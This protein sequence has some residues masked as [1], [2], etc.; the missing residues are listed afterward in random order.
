[1]LSKKFG[2]SIGALFIFPISFGVNAS[3]VTYANCPTM[4]PLPVVGF[5]PA[6]MEPINTLGTTYDTALQSIAQAVTIATTEQS[7]AIDSAF[8]MIM[9][10]MVETSQ[11]QHMQEIEIDRQ[12][13]EM[14][15]A[16]EAD[17]ADRQEQLESMLF[18]GDPSM[19]QP[20]EGEVRAIDPDS[21]SYKFV[22]QMCTSGKMQQMMTSRSVVNRAVENRNR[23]N[24]KITN[25]IQVVSSID[26]AAKQNIDMHYDI[27]CSPDDYMAN[28][29]DTES[30]APNADL[31]AIVFMYPSG[32]V[33]ENQGYT[34]TFRTNYTYSPVESLAAYQY[35]KNVTGTLFIPPPTMDEKDDPNK[36]RF[37]AGYNQMVS[38]VSLSADSLLS[39]S[40]AREPINNEGLVLSQLDAINYMIQENKKPEN[41]RNLKSASNNG[42]MLEIQR[43]MALSQRIRFMIL[44]QRETQR[45]LKAANLSIENTK[46]ALE[47]GM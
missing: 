31:E 45:L 28:L 41:R 20:A 23:R 22:K 26:A 46:F 9:A 33:D 3:A 40:S 5:Q 25:N 8:N 12:Y 27:F 14:M 11:N 13:Q 32:F 15:M 29:C 19:M 18:P 17:L 37:I 42:L 4:K 39:L 6:A 2:L 10:N 44:Q 1:M 38:A 36:S 16:Y 21:P 43:Q 7:M 30:V 47:E 35:I 24:Q 34:E